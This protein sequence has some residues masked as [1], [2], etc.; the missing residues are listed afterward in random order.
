MNE[1][2]EPELMQD[3]DV[4]VEDVDA[5][6]LEEIESNGNRFNRSAR[7]RHEYHEVQRFESAEAFQEW[8]VSTGSEIWESEKKHT[9]SEGMHVIYYRCLN[10]QCPG[11]GKVEFS[12]TSQ[13]VSYLESNVGHLSGA[14][15]SSNNLK[16]FKEEIVRL[17]E[18]GLKPKKI[19]MELLVSFVVLFIFNALG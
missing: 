11:R 16:T 7:P 1:S 8:W 12:A 9:T 2:S 10:K 13:C 18:L 15:A 5:P 6:V 17:M 14:H 3:S 19:R 4:E